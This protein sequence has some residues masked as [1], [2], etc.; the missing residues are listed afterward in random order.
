[1]RIMIAAA[2][3]A[4]LLGACNT[5]QGFGRDLNALGDA[6]AAYEDGGCPGRDDQS[7]WD[8]ESLS[9]F[10]TRLTRL[11]AASPLPEL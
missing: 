2:L 8:S 4:C 1:M 9:A 3:G 10:R 11:L 7:T 5:I 6:I